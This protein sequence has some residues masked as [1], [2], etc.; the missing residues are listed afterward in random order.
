MCFALLENPTTK[1]L[2]PVPYIEHTPQYDSQDGPAAVYRGIG[3]AVRSGDSRRWGWLARPCGRSYGA[4]F[5]GR[6][7]CWCFYSRA[8]YWRKE[9][10]HRVENP[11]F[12]PMT[13]GLLSV[14][15]AAA[16][17]KG[18]QKKITHEH[19]TLVPF[20]FIFE[21]ENVCR[22]HLLQPSKA[23]SRCP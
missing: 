5:S 18:E 17:A 23:Y 7:A 2:S 13:E 11:K 10:R 16:S 22:S 20:A 3:R 4:R 14:A 15:A 1:Q 21:P 6:A 9:R 19:A 12:P 8:L